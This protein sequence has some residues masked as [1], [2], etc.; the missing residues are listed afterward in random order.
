MC[1]KRVKEIG[2]H[3][4]YG[5][6]LWN[7]QLLLNKSFVFILTGA[8]F[9]ACP[10]AWYLVNKWLERFS[11]RT[12]TGIW[13]FLASGFLV[14]IVTLTVAVWQSWRFTRRNPV[15]VLRYE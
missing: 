10:V 3:K 2:I 13:I 9:I 1:E 14:T 7:L 6:R 15:D 4:I 5:A 12:N 8:F 11:Y